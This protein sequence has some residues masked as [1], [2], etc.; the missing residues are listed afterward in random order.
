MN[1]T[2]EGTFGDFTTNVI[3]VILKV[4]SVKRMHKNQLIKTPSLPVSRGQHL[5]IIVLQSK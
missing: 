5:R 3:Y 2:Q 1:G 4:S